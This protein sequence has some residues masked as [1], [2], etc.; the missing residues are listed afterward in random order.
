MSKDL[1]YNSKKQQRNLGKHG[2][3]FELASTVLDDP[4]ARTLNDYSNHN[5]ERYFTI[6][7]SCDGRILIVNWTIRDDELRIISARPSEPHQQRDYYA[8]RK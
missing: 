8:H 1:Q 4:Y 5:E 6:G 3:S 7:M 2:I